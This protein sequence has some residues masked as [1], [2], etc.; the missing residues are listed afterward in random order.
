MN[1]YIKNRIDLEKLAIIEQCESGGCDLDEKNAGALWDWA[2]SIVYDVKDETLS[3][4]LQCE[5]YYALNELFETLY[6]KPFP[7]DEVSIDSNGYYMGNN[8]TREQEQHNLNLDNQ[9]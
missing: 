1:D 5:I 2:G 3:E 7:D 6:K 9:I 4:H 8:L